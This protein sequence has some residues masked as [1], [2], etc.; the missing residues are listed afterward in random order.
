MLLYKVC[1][2]ESGSTEQGRQYKERAERV[3]LTATRCEYSL[4]NVQNYY[5]ILRMCEANDRGT[6]RTELGGST[7]IAL[8]M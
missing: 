6:L 3:N 1:A 7:Y 4:L 2:E 8:I 5:F